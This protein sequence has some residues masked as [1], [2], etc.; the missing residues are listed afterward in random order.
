M[1]DR[2]VLT[3]AQG[4]F[5]KELELSAGLT[6]PG[7]DLD[8]LRGSEAAMAFRLEAAGLVH[9]PFA[10]RRGTYWDITPLGRSALASQ[11][12]SR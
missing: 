3:K 11:E 9:R 2:V 12:K 7:Y 5:L 8:I 6:N 10:H 1:G 4:K